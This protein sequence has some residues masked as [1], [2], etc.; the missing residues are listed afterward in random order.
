VRGVCRRHDLLAANQNWDAMPNSNDAAPSATR[1]AGALPGRPQRCAA[2]QL[3]LC[4]SREE[5]PH[6]ALTEMPGDALQRDTAYSCQTCGCILVR[7]S[8]A[9]RPGWSHHR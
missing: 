7:S 5:R 4:K 3:Q 2:C 9:T 6:A 1:Q 8:D